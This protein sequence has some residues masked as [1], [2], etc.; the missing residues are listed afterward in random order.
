MRPMLAA[1]LAISLAACSS[2]GSAPSAS[3]RGVVV[4]DGDPS[5]L[6]RDCKL[7]GTASGRSLFG[8]SDEARVQT[9][10]NDAR[11]KAAAMGATHIVFLE[12]DTKGMLSRGNAQARA[13]R[14]DAKPS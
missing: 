7:L 5:A 9:A 13:Y 12:A 2:T 11:E 6:N 14:C 3:A 10:M 8:G 1:L 4:V